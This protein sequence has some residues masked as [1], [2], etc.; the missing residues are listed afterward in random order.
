MNVQK[1]F[2]KKL[3]NPKSVYGL[4]KLFSKTKPYSPRIG[5]RIKETPT[6]KKLL[7]IHKKVKSIENLL[8]GIGKLDA[9][10]IGVQDKAEKDK[11]KDKKKEGKK[12]NKF[13]GGII[14]P[15]KTGF[16]DAIRNF[17]TYTF[18]GWLFT[19]LQPHLDKMQFIL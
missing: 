8:G 14:K 15:P 17:V 19:F 16:L 2:N 13:L 5:R 7:S 9:K 4:G 1:F 18:L 11:K 3:R 12:K 6:L 10:I